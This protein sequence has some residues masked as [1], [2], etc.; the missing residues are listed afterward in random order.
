MKNIGCYYSHQVK[1]Q[2][3]NFVFIF[4]IVLKILK[5]SIYKKIP[6]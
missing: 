1:E 2:K 5:K 3:F 6:L 4:F